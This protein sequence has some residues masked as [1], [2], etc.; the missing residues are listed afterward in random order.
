MLYYLN[1]FWKITTWSV[2]LSRKL[3][4]NPAMTTSVCLELLLY[5]CM[6]AI[7]WKTKLQKFSIFS[8]FLARKE[9]PRNF[10]VFTWTTFEK[11]KTSCSSIIFYTISISL[12]ENSWVNL[13]VEVT[14]N[15]TKVWSFFIRTIT[16]S[17]STT[18]RRYSK[19]SDAVLLT[20]SFQKL[21]I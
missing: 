3:R 1:P 5:I 6:A 9:I 7:G 18:S 12:T 4:D 13:V 21:A 8:F 20:R 19:L 16:F 14:K 10:K 2:L 11:M 17:T 15:M